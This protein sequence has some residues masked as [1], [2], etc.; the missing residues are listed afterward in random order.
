MYQIDK[1]EKWVTS[2]GAS[3]LSPSTIPLN[4]LVEDA[5]R[6]VDAASKYWN[7]SGATPGLEKAG[8]GLT[9]ETLAQLV[10][11]K[12]AILYVDEQYKDQVELD[13]DKRR[14][15]SEGKELLYD[16]ATFLDW[17]AA[18]TEEDDKISKKTDRVIRDHQATDPSTPD[19]L[20]HALYD[21]ASLSKDILIDRGAVD[22]LSVE[23]VDQAYQLVPRL[24]DISQDPTPLSEKG[25][26]LFRLRQQ[27]SHLLQKEL[28]MVRKAARFVFRHHPDIVSQFASGY[29]EKSDAAAYRSRRI[30]QAFYRRLN[31]KVPMRFLPKM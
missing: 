22:G 30:S 31:Q 10:Y 27:L 23:K 5:Q 19:E 17:Y 18:A 7:S 21:Y 6:V 3:E 11:L 15:F 20:A 8:L 24:V 1:L 4:A 25:Q 9:R 16:F 26:Q 28:E 14:Q 13:F 29:H 2:K 12:N